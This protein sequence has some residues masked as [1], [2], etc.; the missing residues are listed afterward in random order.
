MT[1]ACNVL[2][3]IGGAPMI[4][5]P[6]FI[7]HFPLNLPLTNVTVDIER[8]S[9][10]SVRNF[11]LI[12]STDR[13]NSKSIGGAYEYILSLLQA[14]C[15]QHGEA[16]VFSGNASLQLEAEVWGA[17]GTAQRAPRVVNMSGAIEAL[18]AWQKRTEQRQSE[19][20]AKQA[21]ALPSSS[22]A[23]TWLPCPS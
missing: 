6:G 15:D 22:R 11:M 1:L 18:R 17:D 8:F 2:N 12:E 9:Q 21:N 3:A 16:A 20:L 7:P 13:I 5:A 23:R 10:R 14:L 19:A 4:D